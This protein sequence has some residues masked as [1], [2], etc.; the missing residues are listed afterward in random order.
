MEVLTL[1]T[2][3]DLFFFSEMFSSQGPNTKYIKG[4][5]HLPAE[6]EGTVVPT[7][8]SPASLQFDGILIRFHSVMR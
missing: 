4:K 6:N 7:I 3:L 2:S 5:L 1:K 8:S